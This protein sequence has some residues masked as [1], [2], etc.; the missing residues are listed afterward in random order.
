MADFDCVWG[1]ESRSLGVPDCRALIYKTANDSLSAL[2][3][4]HAAF[5]VVAMERKDLSEC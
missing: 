2:Q 4:N 1:C 5:E 3:S